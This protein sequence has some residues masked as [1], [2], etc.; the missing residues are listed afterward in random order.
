MYDLQCQRK[1]SIPN[2][3]FLHRFKRP[4]LGQ[5]Y[6]KHLYV[7]VTCIDLQYKSTSSL[8]S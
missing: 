3:M 5:I 7:S 6:V 2:G 4:M 1:I 8:S